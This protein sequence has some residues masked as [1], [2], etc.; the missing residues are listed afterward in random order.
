MINYYSISIVTYLSISLVV[1]IFLGK[2][3]YS[4][5][6]LMLR[7]LFTSNQ[8]ATSLNNLLLL[9]YYLVNIGAI[10][11]SIVLWPSVNNLNHAIAHTTHNLGI[12]LLSLGVLH[13][14]NILCLRHLASKPYLIS[15][16]FHH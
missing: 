13:Y 2:A 3:F 16:Y 6:Y 15:Q 12:V 7:E 9:G 11:L 8:V 1:T 5:G 10:I 14:N 4:K